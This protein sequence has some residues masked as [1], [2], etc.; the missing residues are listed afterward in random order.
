MINTVEHGIRKSRVIID[1]KE[2]SKE[3]I[4][5]IVNFGT[6]FVLKNPDEIFLKYVTY[7]QASKKA[8]SGLGLYIA[9]RI[10]DAHGGKIKAE[11]QPNKYVKFIF[12][13][14]KK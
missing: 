3:F 4:F 5:S 2:T 9:K 14:P 13:L 6:G 12:T 1:L 10:I 8:S 11:S 7:A